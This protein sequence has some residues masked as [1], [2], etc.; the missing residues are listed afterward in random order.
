MFG[1]TQLM[2]GV[3]DML[4]SFSS[5]LSRTQKSSTQSLPSLF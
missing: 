3:P 5:S 2:D 1:V 4:S